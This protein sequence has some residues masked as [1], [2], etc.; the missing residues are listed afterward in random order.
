MGTAIVTIKIMPETPEVNL[1]EVQV[2]A[3]EL[4]KG[5]AGDTENKIEIEPIA[6]GLKALNIIFVVDEAKGSP[7]AVA[8]KITEIEGVQS[9]EVTDVR[10]AI[11]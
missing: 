9:A 3:L 8:D 6:F 4:I 1:E 10:R 7:D 11:G 2:K 5:Y